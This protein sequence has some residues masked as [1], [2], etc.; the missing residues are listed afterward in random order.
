MALLPEISGTLSVDT[1]LLRPLLPAELRGLS[2]GRVQA[3]FTPTGARIGTPGVRYRGQALGL[4]AQVDWR[5]GFGLDAL[6]ASGT[7]TTGRSRLP[8]VLSGG[9]LNVTDAQISARDVRPLLDTEQP[10]PPGATFRGNLTVP[11]IGHFSLNTLGVRGTLTSGHSQAPL[12]LRGGTLSLRGALLDIRDVRPFL[13]QGTPLPS[14]GTFRGDLSISNLANFSLNGVR[15]QGVLTSGR[16]QAPLSLRGGALRVTG[17]LLDV[18]DVRPFVPEDTSLPA[19]GTFRGDLSISNLA[20]FSLNGVRAQGVL[21]SGRSQAPLSLQ[22]GALRVTGGLLD[23]RDL[24]P[25]VDDPASLPQSGTFQGD[26]YV[27]NLNKF[28]LQHVRARGVLASG[29]SRLPLDIRN[30]TLRVSGGVLNVNDVRR[31]LDMEL[32][33]RATF[34]GDLTLRN[35]GDFAPENLNARGVLDAG[36]SRLPLTLAGRAL[37]VTGGRL[38]L[39]DVQPF[40]AVPAR[41]VL[42]GDLYLPDVLNPDLSGTRADLI[43]ERLTA[44]D[45]S[46][47]SASGRLRLRGGQLWTD[48]SGQLQDTPLTLRGDVYPHANATLEAGGLTARLTGRAEGTLNLSATGEYQGRAVDLQGTLNDLLPAGRAAR[49]ALSGTVSGAQLDLTLNEA[50]R[51]WQDWRISGS[52]LVP[53]ARTLDPGLRGSLSGSVGGTLGRVGAQV[54]G[55]VNDIALNVPATWSGGEL[56]VRG[57]QALSPELG[58]ATLSGLAFPRLNLSGAAQLSGD[59]AG[60]YDL[61][62]SGEYS[63]PTARLSGQLA[64]AP[65]SVHPSGLNIGG[66]GVNATL[67]AG[68]WQAQLSGPAV[69]G[70]VSGVL[71]AQVNGEDIPLGL[72]RADLNLNARYR[73]DGDNLTLSGPLAW[74]GGAGAQGGWRGNV[75]VRGTLGGESLSAQATGIGPLSVTAR[76]GDASLRAELSRLAPVRPQGWVA[77]D[78]WDMGAL[79][80]R[81]DQL[82]LT[83]RADLTGPGWQSVQARLSGQLDDVTGELSGELSGEWNAAQGGTF[84]L[85][86]PRVQASGALQG[87]RYDVDARLGNGPQSAQVGLARLLPAEWGLDALKASGRLSVRGSLAGGT[88][89]LEA[90]GLEVNGD[91]R[92]AGPFTLYGRAS[93]RPQQH[94]LEAALAGGYGGGIFRVGGTLP[95]GLNV[96]MANISLAQFA[97]EGFDPGRLNGEATLSGPLDRAAL[98]GALRTTGGNVDAAVDLLGRLDDPR[99]E[100]RLNLRGEQSGELTLSARDFDLPGRTF[101]GE[102]RGQVRRGDTVADLDLRG[103]WPKLSGQVRVQDPALAQP[104]TLRGQNGQFTLDPGVEGAGSGTVTLAPGAGWQPTL[105]AQ[106]DLNP[107]ALLPGAAGEARLRLNVGGELSALTVQGTLSAPEASVSGVTVRDLSGTFGG[108]LAGGL[109][110]LSGELTQGGRPAGTLSAGRLNLSG[111][112][113][114][115]AGSTLTLSG[116]VDLGGPNDK[117]SADLNAEVSGAL[118]GGLRLNYA[119][120]LLRAGGT[121]EGLGYRAALDVQGSEA[122]GWSGT[123]SAR[124][125]EGASEVL[126]TPADLTVSGPWKAPR[127]SGTLGLLNAPATLNA[128]QDGATLTLAATPT[129]QASGELRVAPDPAGVW[130][131]AGA[132]TIDSPRMRLSLTPRGELTDPVV[133][134][135]AGRG[136]WQA[137]GSVSRAA[138]RLR[139]SDGEGSGSLNWQD[140]VLTADLP[141]LDLAGLRWRGLAGRLSAQGTVNLGTANLGRDAAAS[142]ALPFRIDGLRSPW[143]VDALNLPLS[144][145]V[146][147]TLR[148][149]GG[150]PA[151]QAQATLGSDGTAHGQATLSAAQQPDGKWV[152]RVQGRVQQEGGSLSADVRSDAAGLTGQ[153]QATGYPVALEGQTLALNGAAQLRGQTFTADLALGGVAGEATLS[154]GGSLGAALPALTGLTALQGTG[155]G[156]NLSGTLSRVNLGELELVPDLSGTVS[157]ELDVTDGAGQF[158]LRSADLNLAGEALP[159]RFEGVLVGQDWRIRGYLGD[160]DVFAGVSSGVLSG[161]AELQ[162]LPLGAVANALAGQ[163]LADG[164]VTGVARFEAPL[165]DP[166]SGRATVVA[167]R[168]R[169]TTLPGEEGGETAESETLTGS[170]SLDFSNRELRS[171]NVQLVGAGSWDIQGQYTRERVDVRANFTETTFTPLL[172]LIP[173]L[174]GQSPRLK[175]SLNVAV[176]GSYGQPDGTLSG[177]GLRG[178]LAG[179]SLE[180]PTLSGRLDQSGRWTL[181]G[182]VRTGGALNSAGTVQGS[183]LW[184]NWQ[185]SESALN[186]SGQLSAG[187]V[188]TLP[189]V[190]ATLS[191]NRADP[192]RWE[193]DARSVS[194]SAVTGQGTLEVRGQLIPAWDLSVRARNYDLALP[195]VYLRESALNGALTLRQDAGEDDIHVSGSADFARAVLG[196][197]D[198]A[199]NLDALVPSP[200]QTA[201]EAATPDNFVSPLPAQYTTF[202][203]PET[204]GAG[205]APPLSPA[206]PLL[207]RLVL[208]DI[209]VSFSGGIQLQESLAQAELGGSLRLSGSGARPQIAG[210]LSGQRGTLL[211][212]DTQFNLR[213]LDIEFSGNSPYPAFQLLAEGRV[214]PLSGGAAVPITLDVQGNFLEDGSGSA[215]LDLKTALRCTEQGAA[216]TDDRTGQPY[217]ESQLYALVLT[218][219]PNVE[220]LPE[221]LGGLGATALSTALNVFVLGELSRN[222]ADALGVDVLRFA[223]VLVGEGGAT[224]TIGSQL[225]ENL[226]LEYQVDLTGEGLINAAYNTPDG[227]FTFKVSTEFDFGESQG[228]R[229][230][231]SAA[232]NINERTSV[233]FNIENTSETNRFSVGVQYR[234]PRDFWQRQ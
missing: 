148:L 130:R 74:N 62:V 45:L 203:Q 168:I 216:C 161:N 202:P 129:T 81:P 199:D 70:T 141:G 182:G 93:Y 142:S 201:G 110:G 4:S 38:D 90:S 169:L 106:A 223:P 6:R 108:T 73:R 25:L 91:Q 11:D 177:R 139:V 72:G 150:R 8:F 218:G 56:R 104:V 151:V 146:S 79:W 225:T 23:V 206:L 220:N 47:T 138:G 67:Q 36:N 136:S 57:A 21:T 95:G 75:T 69:R 33:A 111:L 102:L 123:V 207:E 143:R 170:G 219:V 113:A 22:N 97:A 5:R 198:T 159:T 42:R 193:L 34:R 2:G 86:G 76:L 14:A 16:S 28:D 43:T 31:W 78:R 87:G 217:T 126:T 144:G 211:L 180:V 181:G 229:P 89:R 98:S 65:G 194:R 213:G 71:G 166:L 24:R 41:G 60:S 149:E 233:A 197:P 172:T 205:E 50:G 92:D 156:Y 127:L 190:Q 188:G 210:R 232:Y 32:P 94:T 109:A 209:P 103:L 18:R 20:N 234:L 15:A 230:S 114:Q 200:E 52:L 176:M 135:M 174:A 154:G 107:L 124:D 214:R 27:P 37:T 204:P 227:R 80:D 222:L 1:A 51:E 125:N 191:Q 162:G 137:T 3:A 53:D 215:T 55:T 64:G 29:A 140:Q 115:A 132:A 187:A 152:G 158:V 171:I 101:A 118:S 99:L 58:T 165:A 30:D 192:E 184:R 10:L 44:T 59:L 46:G 173:S 100:A 157:G 122:G 105:S 120:G 19:D 153:V 178:S 131:W 133:G 88:E 63:A 212:R 68:R 26:L 61:S 228:F 134:V 48:L 112:S 221:N 185:L 167:E 121:L 12:T 195:G 83:G 189:G 40:F 179:M 160:T 128:A 175:G 17:G 119:G 155:S 164:R 231:V 116:P 82:R 208:D 186:Y 66:T 224:L 13:P 35:L 163:R 147:G 183:G 145:D 9:A 7:L 117:P 84:A 54:Q 85:S 49:A 39:A 226:Y 196:R 77:L 96:Q